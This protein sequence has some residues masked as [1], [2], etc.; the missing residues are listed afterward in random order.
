[1]NRSRLFKLGLVALAI[2]FAQNYTAQ[3]VP[4]YKKKRK[5]ATFSF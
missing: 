3:S 4:C 5:Y 2:L 1:M